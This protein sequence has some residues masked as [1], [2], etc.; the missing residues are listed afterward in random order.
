MA[1]GADTRRGNATKQSGCRH[2]TVLRMSAFDA[3]VAIVRNMACHNASKRIPMQRRS[4]NQQKLRT[5]IL[6]TDV[7]VKG[8][9]KGHCMFH[10]E[11][12]HVQST[13]LVSRI[14]KL[15]CCTAKQACCT[16]H[17]V[18]I[19]HSKLESCLSIKGHDLAQILG[20]V[21]FT[22]LLFSGNRYLKRKYPLAFL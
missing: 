5:A 13:V 16:V 18:L 22:R 8:V 20:V 9:E 4:G 1:K 11:V 17:L 14:L 7:T 15:A 21:T 3:N 12:C 6:K 19:H 2:P 10:A